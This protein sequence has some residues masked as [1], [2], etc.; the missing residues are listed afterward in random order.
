MPQ[1]VVLI[2]RTIINHG[3]RML[4]PDIG[5][6]GTAADTTARVRSGLNERRDK[7]CVAV[8][9]RLDWDL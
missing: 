2:D 1:I 9:S 3:R 8:L 6:V 5:V 7:A 4:S